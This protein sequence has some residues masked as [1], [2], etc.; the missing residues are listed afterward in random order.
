MNRPSVR[1][2]IEDLQNLMDGWCPVIVAVVGHVT[3]RINMF[4]PTGSESANRE[5]RSTYPGSLLPLCQLGKTCL[6]PVRAR[7]LTL[8]FVWWYQGLFP[9]RTSW[10]ACY[11]TTRPIFVLPVMQVI[12][13]VGSARLLAC[14]DDLAGCTGNIEPPSRRVCRLFPCR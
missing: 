9:F 11:D 8:A 3:A 6:E 5:Q 13:T 7:L 12:V 1:L 10:P 14:S 4:K 2:P